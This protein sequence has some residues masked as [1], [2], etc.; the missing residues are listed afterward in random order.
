A[1]RIECCG[2][3]RATCF[4]LEAADYVAIDSVEVVGGQYGVRAVGE[5]FPADQHQVGVAVLRSIGHDQSNDPFFTGQS[6]WFVIEGIIAHGAGNDDG[7]GIYLS[8][9][10]DWLIVR[11]SELYGNSSSDF[12]IN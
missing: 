1:V 10:G 4:N 11:D 9:G 5:D 12:Q 3:D 6:D 7:H 2:D 8:N